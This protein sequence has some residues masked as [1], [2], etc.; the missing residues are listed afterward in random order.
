ME[1]AIKIDYYNKLDKYDDKIDYLED[2]ICDLQDKL[3]NLRD[4]KIE[5]EYNPPNYNKNYIEL[6]GVRKRE[7]AKNIFYTLINSYHIKKLFLLKKNKEDLDYTIEDIIYDSLKPY[8]FY[9]K[10]KIYYNNDG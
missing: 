9:P 7:L 4:K 10:N 3:E 1:T 8:Y 2:K 6:F 5:L